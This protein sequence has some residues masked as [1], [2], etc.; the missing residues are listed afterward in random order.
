MNK[1]KIMFTI[2][3]MGNGG[4][5]RVVSVLANQLVKEGHQII[6]TQLYSHECDYKLSDQIVLNCI[7]PANTSGSFRSAKTISNLRR[8]IKTEK[9]DIIISFLANINIYTI[10]ASLGLGIPVIASERNDPGREPSKKYLKILRSL[11]YLFVDGIVF[12]TKDAQAYFNSR[13]Q[14][15]SCIIHNPLAEGLP[16]PSD[17]DRNNQIVS[18]CRLTGQKNLKMLIDAFEML[19]KE[20]SGYT[21]VIYGEGEQ[22][23]GLENYIKELNAMDRISLPGYVT[24]VHEKIRDSRMFVLSSDYEG[25]P[26]ALMEA[27]AMGIPCISTDCPIGGPAFLIRN[28]INGILIPVSDTVNLYKAMCE[29]IEDK[30]LASRLSK[31][32]REIN[33]LANVLNVS[34]SWTAYME[35]TMSK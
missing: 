19:N 20:H 10:L 2:D 4:A 13:V 29:I 31:N 27:M 1:Y 3:T 9:P 6:I 7:A 34:K 26:N 25:M 17:K 21:L 35:S 5:E 23:S 18:V 14:A 32:A 28:N 12:Q 24:D 22:R 33:K 30:D 16:V 8:Y 11:C 15:K